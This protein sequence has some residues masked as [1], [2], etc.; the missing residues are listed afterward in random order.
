MQT[1]AHLLTGLSLSSRE[2]G[3]FPQALAYGRR[4]QEIYRQ[5]GDSYGQ[6]QAALT[7]GEPAGR[8]ATRRRRGFCQQAA[9]LGQ[10]IGDRSG[11]AASHYRL[12]QIAADLRERE[13]A[14]RHLRLALEIGLEIGETPLVL[15]TLL[16]IGCL[17]AAE[18]E[19]ERAAEILRCLL[20]QPQLPERQ[21][22]R[23]PGAGR[24]P[25]PPVGGVAPSLEEA[26]ALAMR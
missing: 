14:L 21:R 24:A 5:L 1:A 22:Q 13:E 23:Q 3:Q 17:L 26:A 18:G 7:L 8:W 10:E 12:G 11:E 20:A 19:R 9:Q 2:L 15:D 25:A 6:L 16:E 4:S